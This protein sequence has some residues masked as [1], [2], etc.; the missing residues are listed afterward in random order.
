VVTA[1]AETE[2]Q[3]HADGEHDR[4]R[5]SLGFVNYLANAASIGIVTGSIGL[6]PCNI[7]SVALVTATDEIPIAKA[8]VLTDKDRHLLAVFIAA[9]AA[10]MGGGS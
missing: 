7:L 3:E 8:T 1:Q 5:V 4:R 6:T 2:A 9:R 10:S